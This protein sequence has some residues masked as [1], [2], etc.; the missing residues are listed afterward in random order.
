MHSNFWILLH[1]DFIATY[2]VQEL[3][4]QLSKEIA[5][6]E[7]E[8]TFAVNSPAEGCLVLFSD[9]SFEFT[10]TIGRHDNTQIASKL[11]H[12]FELLPC[13]ITDLILD[14]TAY[15]YYYT[16]QTVNFS[17]P[18]VLSPQKVIVFVSREIVLNSSQSFISIAQTRMG[19]SL[20]VV[21][22]TFWYTSQ[23]WQTVSTLKV[24]L[25]HAKWQKKTPSYVDRSPQ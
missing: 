6:V 24:K 4:L 23:S 21:M 16:N 18:A 15:D 20:K 2:S 7:I 13:S 12:M 25:Q 11:V 5:T 9:S 8:C 1:I 14:V 17:K 22:L 3:R 19:K 10:T